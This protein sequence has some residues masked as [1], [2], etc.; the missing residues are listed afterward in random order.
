MHS[1]KLKTALRFRLHVTLNTSFG[2]TVYVWVV[3]FILRL[4]YMAIILGPGIGTAR[5]IEPF[6]TSQ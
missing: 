4:I 3:V 1:G 6:C 5:N 2:P